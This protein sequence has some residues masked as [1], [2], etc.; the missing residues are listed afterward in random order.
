MVKVKFVATALTTGVHNY[1]KTLHSFGYD[2][3]HLA[4]GEKWGGWRFRMKTYMDICKKEKP[5]E[6]LI[7]T[8]ADDVLV[9]R[10]NDNLQTIFEKFNKDIIVSSETVCLTSTCKDIPNYWKKNGK[11]DSSCFFVNCG[12][13]MGRA[14]ELCTMWKWML[15][16]GF[17]D[18]QIAL[19]H[20]VDSYPE[21]FHV[22]AYNELFY[23]VPRSTSVEIEWSK[24]ELVSLID[25]IDKRK[26]TPYFLHFAGHFT[27]PTIHSAL[28]LHKQPVLYDDI[29]KK[30]LN[31]EAMSYQNLNE[32]GRKYG[33]LI[34]WTI[35]SIF[36]VI[37][38]L[39]AIFLTKKRTK[40]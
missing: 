16:Q 28:V 14:G 7:L 20:Y 2:Y 23:T 4:L 24:N 6:I 8:D 32:G 11:E 36:L 9:T 30:I 13:M 31:T 39:L 34:F 15:D 25:P 27:I 29:A 21:K 35:T 38:I 40:K 18:D 5:D 33:I 19:G 1:T 12:L 22:D 3:E 10:K 37:I 17:Q 26:C